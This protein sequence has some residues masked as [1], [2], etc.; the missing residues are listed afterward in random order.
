MLFAFRYACLRLLLHLA[1]VRMGGKALE[2]EVLLLRHEL[3][4][5]RR[6]LKRSRLAPTDRTIL[7]AFCNWLSRE[8]LGVLVQ[9]ETVIGWHRE[10][11]RWKWAAFGTRRKVGRPR[12]DPELRELI[13][14]DGKG[15]SEKA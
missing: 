8:K 2:A 11:V 1:D 12:M 10:L 5:L 6:Q 7:A 9:P 3:R 15:G 13:L 14:R 4:V